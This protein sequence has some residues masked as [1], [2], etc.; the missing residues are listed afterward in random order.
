MRYTCA[1]VK[2]RADLS[3]MSK[4]NTSIDSKSLSQERYGRLAARYVHSDTHAKGEDLERLFAIGAP[5]PSWRALDIATGGG[6]TALKFAPLVAHITVS[7]FASPMLAAAEAHLRSQGVTNADYQHADA[8]EMPF[9]DAS[10][11]LITCRLAPHHFP[12]PSR[13]FLEAARVLR[14]GG[15]LLIQDHCAPED[16]DA[17]DYLDA[18]ETLR[19]P[20]H[21]RT[22]RESD[23]QREFRDVGLTVVVRDMLMKR[24][25]LRS[26]ARRQDCSDAII[27]RLEVLLARAPQ[28]AREWVQPR[29]LGSKDASFANPNIIIKGQKA[30]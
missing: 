28:I 6:H 26:W 9:A 27:E 14:P 25:D 30:G 1:N 16:E 3:V 23:W 2:W 20:S 7:D 19:D 17:A 15:Y 22:L 5:Q 12:Q 4:Q 18:F 13:F 10:Y 11:D 24:H 8:E 29:A 21:S